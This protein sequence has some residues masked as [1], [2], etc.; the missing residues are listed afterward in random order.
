MFFSFRLFSQSSVD[1]MHSLEHEPIV[2][3]NRGNHFLQ[4]RETLNFAS[5]HGADSVLSCLFG[6]TFAFTNALLIYEQL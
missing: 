2:G 6:I 5:K 3:G 4:F 1:S